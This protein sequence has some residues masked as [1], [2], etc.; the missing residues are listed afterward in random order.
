MIALKFYVY[1]IINLI[2]IKLKLKKDH[3]KS[4]FIY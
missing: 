2:L 3:K 1:K 4:G